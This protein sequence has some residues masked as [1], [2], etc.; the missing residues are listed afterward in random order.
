MA[1]SSH[2]ERKVRYSRFVEQE[3]RC[4]L[5]RSRATANATTAPIANRIGR[6]RP[7]ERRN[8]PA[9]APVAIATA[10]PMQQVAAI[11][12]PVSPARKAG[13]LLARGSATGLAT[14]GSGRD[15]EVPLDQLLQGRRVERA[16]LDVGDLPARSDEQRRRHA[17]R[18]HCVEEGTMRVDAGGIRYA[19]LVG[20]VDAPA[21]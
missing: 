18:P 19:R 15:T 16:G 8:D 1:T 21:P 17:R 7:I 2:R 20:E 11:S 3:S 5:S 12:P 6:Y 9:P 14:F 4:L 13:R 10:G